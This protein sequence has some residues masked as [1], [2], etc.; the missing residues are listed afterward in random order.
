LDAGVLP[1]IVLD[2][3]VE[4]VGGIVEYPCPI[5]VEYC[6][7]TVVTVEYCGALLP[8]TRRKYP[9]ATIMISSTRTPAI[10][11]VLSI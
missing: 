4:L 1:V 5:V 6:G 7:A 10:I 9:A 3:I 8:L 2:E 11:D